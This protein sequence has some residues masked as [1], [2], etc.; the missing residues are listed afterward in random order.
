MSWLFE[1]AQRALLL[2]CITLVPLAYLPGI[3]FD[4][5][6]VPK[7]GLL[8]AAVGL[9]LG[10]L[11]W[12][13][14]SGARRLV[15]ASL[16]VPAL[17]LLPLLV[18]WG[19]SSYRTWALWGRYP[20]FQGLLPYA[21]F[22]C[23]AIV[24][25][26]ASRRNREAILWCLAISGAMVGFYLLIQVVGLDPLGAVV[27]GITIVA[28]SS[29]IGNS[30]FAGGFLAIVLPISVHLWLTSPR[31][32]I[33][34]IACTVMVSEGLLLSFSE[35]AYVAALAGLVTLLGFRRQS[36][37]ARLAATM[38]AAS[39]AG[40]LIAGVVVSG[41]ASTPFPTLTSRSHLWA[42]ALGVAANSPLV[43]AGPSAY[44]I[45]AIRYRSVEDAIAHRNRLPGFTPIPVDHQTSD[46]P[47][48]VP[49]AMLANAGVLGLTGFILAAVW[50]FGRGFRLGR[51]DGAGIA[52][53]ASIASYFVVS[54]VTVDEPT[55][56]LAFW[57]A[58]GGLA[59]AT[60]PR[61]EPADAASSIGETRNSHWKKALLGST[62]AIVAAGS[63]WM[64]VALLVADHRVMS[65][66]RLFQAG[67]VG[68]AKEHLAGALSLRG[69]ALYRRL[70][71]EHLGLAALDRG[72]R[73]APLLQEMEQ[74]N[75][76]LTDV[77]DSGAILAWARILNY[78]G[79]FESSGDERALDRYK[80]VIRLDPNS[81]LPVIEASE[82][83]VDLQ[84][85]SEAARL[86]EPLAGGKGKASP[87]FWGTLATL[88]LLE[89]DL[90]AAGDALSRAQELDSNTCR[91]KI[92]AELIAIQTQGTPGDLASAAAFNLQQRCDRGMYGWF[93][94]RLPPEHRSGY[95]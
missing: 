75:R 74:I 30:N 13:I 60:Q 40:A 85:E 8:M 63:V 14:A 59:A 56:R 21:I 7:M 76:Y 24:V 5:V 11:L 53:L 91:T 36:I 90:R 32:R 94:D 22:G 23:L 1:R 52:F 93:V 25:A 43:G 15:N 70:F 46:D 31:W 35:G 19:F 37:R 61:P 65:G 69:D 33:G 42:S 34:A 20:R 87:D 57:T 2:A 54:T 50:L 45:E 16:V 44:A 82:A 41:L 84:R 28:S 86:M 17:I 73:G 6:N 92:A 27:E 77:P 89:G 67:A 95:R 55:L 72:I 88:R 9:L 58:V 66:V 10:L 18:S 3:M 81:P 38:I 39:L 62:A 48:S 51:E 47:H 4:R 78:W 79:T 26:H 49:L 80:A 68:P 83:L 71:A 12:T 29:S 64:A